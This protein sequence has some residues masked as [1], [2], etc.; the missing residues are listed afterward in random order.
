MRVPIHANVWLNGRDMIVKLVY[1]PIFYLLTEYVGIL[2]S[3]RTYRMIFYNIHILL[4][5]LVSIAAIARYI[6][7]LRY[8]LEKLYTLTT[9]HCFIF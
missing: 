6:L 3:F 7:S 9:G 1:H 5:K 2:Y 4:N 8:V